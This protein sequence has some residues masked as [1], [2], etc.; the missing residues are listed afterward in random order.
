VT[1]FVTSSNYQKKLSGQSNRKY[2]FYL[3]KHKI[4]K[5]WSI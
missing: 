4:F 1:N 2:W 5:K 3:V